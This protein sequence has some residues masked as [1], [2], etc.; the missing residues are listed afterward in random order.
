MQGGQG[1]DDYT[2]KM[3]CSG[4]SVFQMAVSYCQSLCKYPCMARIFYTHCFPKV[5]ALKALAS[6]FKG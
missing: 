5:L 2:G 3:F 4:L 1:V 6:V